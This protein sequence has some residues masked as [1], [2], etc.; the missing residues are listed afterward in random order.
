MISVSDFAASIFLLFLFCF[1][2]TLIALTSSLSSSSSGST[3]L[4]GTVSLILME[5]LLFLFFFWCGSSCAARPGDERWIN[6]VAFSQDFIHF[7]K[8][9][10]AFSSSTGFILV[11]KNG[12]MRGD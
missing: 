12:L 3:S 7:F 1:A 10:K 5:T 2:L 6:V 9:L 8:K 4:W 11:Q